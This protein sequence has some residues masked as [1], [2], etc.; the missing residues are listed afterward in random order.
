MPPTPRPKTPLAE[1]LEKKI[2]E[3]QVVA[4]P[5]EQQERQAL[6]YLNSLESLAGEAAKEA[7]AIA[8]KIKQRKSKFFRMPRVSARLA[9][10]WAA[11]K[12]GVKLKDELKKRGLRSLKDL[13]ADH[14]KALE[15][16]KK[17]AR[18]LEAF[19]QEPEKMIEEL[20]KVSKASDPR[21]A[22]KEFLSNF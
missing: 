8:E 6:N 3:R 9:A 11:R 10:L 16:A 21:E 4:R 20:E 7:K 14:K 1:F 15:K 17:L 12:R 2:Q 13:H 22:F 5:K 18:L 19:K